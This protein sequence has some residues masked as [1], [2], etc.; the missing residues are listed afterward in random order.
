MRISRPASAHA[1]GS[2]STAFDSL[3]TDTAPTGLQITAITGT[4]LT[5]GATAQSG[6]AVTGG[7]TGLRGTYDIPVGDSV[8]V[9]YTATVTSA[10]VLGSQLTNLAD[11][12]W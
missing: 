12:V 1:A 9:T 8:T 7:G 11:V 5:G 3:L 2:G 10:T 4:T 6:A